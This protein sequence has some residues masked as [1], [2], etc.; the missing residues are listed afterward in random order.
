[1]TRVLITGVRGKTGVPLAE[2]LAA[3]PGVDVLGGS[4]DPSSVAIDGVRPTSFSWDDPSGWAAATEAVDAVYVVRPDRADAPELVAALLAETPSE[5]RI[6]LL[7]EFDAD[8]FDPGSWALRVEQSVRE[9]GHPWTILRPS[10]FMQVFND[11]RYYRD[12]LT[13]QG[14]LPFPARGAA[15]AWIDVRD[16]AAVADR[17][18][19]DEAHDGAVYE[20]SGPEAMTLPRTAEV[21]SDVLHRPITHIEVTIADAVADMPDGFERDEFVWTF[22]RLHNGVYSRVTDA[23]EQVTGRPPGSLARLLRHLAANA[24]ARH[25]QR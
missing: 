2:L 3:R 17:A 20:L 14:R 15:V 16:I 11:P 5:A 19:F 6:V 23:V 7:S 9:S 4:S 21:L 12:E 8:S 22:E 10:W 25:S 24:A 13:E 1:M 18:L